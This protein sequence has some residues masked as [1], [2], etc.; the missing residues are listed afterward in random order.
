MLRWHTCQKLAVASRRTL[1]K[2][3]CASGSLALLQRKTTLLNSSESKL[4]KIWDVHTHLHGVPGS[5]P[6]ERI[7]TLIRIA[8]RLEIERLILSQ[9]YSA[10]RHPTPQQLR[11]ENDRVLEAVRRF[12]NR[13]YGS[14]YLS[15]AHLEFSLQEFDR[16]VRDG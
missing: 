1:L 4:T 11:D 3:L 15:P 9:G 13:V 14:V 8:D 5:T 6:K 12:P 7:E 16:C 10:N 2:T